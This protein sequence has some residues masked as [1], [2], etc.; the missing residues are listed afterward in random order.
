MDLPQLQQAFENYLNSENSRSSPSEQD[1]IVSS[2]HGKA[3]E[4]ICRLLLVERRVIEGDKNLQRR[5]VALFALALERFPENR[6]H[7]ELISC[8]EPKVSLV[9]IDISSFLI[10]FSFGPFCSQDKSRLPRPAL[11]GSFRG[12][13]GNESWNPLNG[14]ETIKNA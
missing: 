14:P 10:F 11:V 1:K 4:E 2:L 6:G 5:L 13:N 9:T 12:K 8:K 7:F 3:L